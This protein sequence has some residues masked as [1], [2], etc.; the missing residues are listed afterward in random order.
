MLVAGS[1]LLFSAVT[2]NTNHPTTI[3]Q[4]ITSEKTLLDSSLYLRS[5]RKLL[6]SDLKVKVPYQ[7]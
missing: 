3:K 2:P 4:V 6:I 7:A 1:L 5:E